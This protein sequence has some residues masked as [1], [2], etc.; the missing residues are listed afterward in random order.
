MFFLESALD[1]FNENSLS[2]EESMEELREES[3]SLAESLLIL[4]NEARDFEIECVLTEA[5]A[6][7]NTAQALVKN[8][9]AVYVTA[10]NKLVD[11]LNDFIIHI[12]ERIYKIVDKMV[13]YINEHK[14]ELSRVQKVSIRG[15]VKF[16][17]SGKP[18][19]NSL[20][21]IIKAGQHEQKVFLQ[22]VQSNKNLL[23]SENKDRKKQL[24]QLIDAF[25]ADNE[26]ASVLKKEV[27]VSGAVYYI[28][29]ISKGFSSLKK[30]AKQTFAE[31]KKIQNEAQDEIKHI[32]KFGK[33][34]EYHNK[35]ANARAYAGYHSS[36][37][38][39]QSMTLLSGTVEAQMVLKAAVK[40]AK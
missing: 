29:N 8:M 14:A 24:A 36:I 32:K 16:K 1:E 18:L 13:P 12:E 5:G 35:I 7:G 37:L 19:S 26:K 20:D 17:M 25:D 31:I 40:A 9:I 28:K 4:E 3:H 23:N 21:D 22:I 2:I 15:V 30:A 10:M 27:S 11:G 6:V 39:N 38:R 33:R 34:S